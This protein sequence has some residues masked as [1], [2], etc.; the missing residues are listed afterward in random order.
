MEDYAYSKGCGSVE[1]G[2]R[3]R[4]DCGGSLVHRIGRGSSHFGDSRSRGIRHDIRPIT[5]LPV[6]FMLLNQ[7]QML[8]DA[9]KAGTARAD[10][11]QTFKKPFQTVIRPPTKNHNMHDDFIR[12]PPKVPV[13]NASCCCRP[14]FSRTWSRAR[15]CPVQA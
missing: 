9:R 14:N 13:S 6:L 1:G 7:H 10:Q 5:T 3:V 2:E 4:Q 8:K 15:S 12:N 11:G